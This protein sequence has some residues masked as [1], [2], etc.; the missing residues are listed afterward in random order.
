MNV[1]RDTRGSRQNRTTLRV[2]FIAENNS[3]Q[4]NS[5]RKVVPHFSDKSSQR[6]SKRHDNIPLCEIPGEIVEL[7]GCQDGVQERYCGEICDSGRLLAE[8]PGPAIVEWAARD[9]FTWRGY[10]DEQGSSRVEE[11]RFAAGGGEAV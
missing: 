4:N 9:R 8:I 6:S 11:G 5:T 10:Y 2:V 1:E 7:A 3:T